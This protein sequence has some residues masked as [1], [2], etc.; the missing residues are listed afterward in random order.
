M[1]LVKK[2]KENERRKKHRFEIQREARYKVT[3]DGLVVASGYAETINICSSGVAF[4]AEGR[5]KRGA[6][7]EL[8]ISWPA[9]LNEHCGMQLIVFGRI[10]WV[11]GQRAACTVEKYEF[12]TQSR[13]LQ[14]MPEPRT[15]GMLQRWVDEMRRTELKIKMAAQA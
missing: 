4:K 8:S 10:L 9:L 3:E 1:E 5:L 6:F 11:L 15:N 14:T 7:V 12:R 13:K 2:E